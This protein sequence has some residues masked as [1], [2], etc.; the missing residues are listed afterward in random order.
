MA[1]EMLILALAVHMHLN[2]FR[3]CAYWRMNVI[4]WNMKR[5]ISKKN[6]LIRKL[7]LNYSVA[8]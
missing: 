8:S 4:F 2:I 1:V 6:W 7:T 3:N 5:K